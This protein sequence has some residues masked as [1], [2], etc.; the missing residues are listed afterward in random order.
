M[1]IRHGAI[2]RPVHTGGGAHP[3]TDADSDSRGPGTA[4]LSLWP[5]GSRLRWRSKLAQRRHWHHDATATATATERAPADAT[6]S[7]GPCTVT[8]AGPGP[9]PAGA[10]LGVAEG[11]PE[12]RVCTEPRRDADAACHRNQAR[13]TT[14]EQATRC[15]QRCDRPFNPHGARTFKLSGLITMG[16]FKVIAW[17]VHT[18]CQWQ[19]RTADSECECPPPGG[20]AP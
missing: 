19:R 10:A 3:R 16:I 2:G 12:A 13:R 1:C 20:E 5:A 14:C 9:P 8:A 7:A 18:L 17:N 4:P 11:P 6:G 15:A